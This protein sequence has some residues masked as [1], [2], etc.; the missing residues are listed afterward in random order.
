MPGAT[1]LFMQLCGAD[2]N[3]EPR[4][5]LEL[6][7]QHGRT[8]AAEV[9]RVAR[10]AMAPVGGRLQSAYSTA[11]LAFAPHTREQYERERQDANRFK[12]RRAELMLTAYDERREPRKLLYP[13]SVVRFSKGFTLVA[14]GGEVVVDYA[15]WLKQAYPKEPLMVAGYS[16]DVA[17]YIPSSR[18]LKEGGYEAEESMIYYAQPGPFTDEVESRVQQTIAETLRRTSK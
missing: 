14:L 8:L 11:S 4:S 13:V 15:L 6:A 18:V 1:A 16:N 17:C 5:R 2:Q 7:E 3:P 9:L 10:G 12:A